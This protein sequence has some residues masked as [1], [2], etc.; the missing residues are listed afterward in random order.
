MAVTITNTTITA[1]NTIT[2][3]TSN[4]ATSSVIDATEV[5]TLTPTVPS[6]RIA[7]RI[8]VANSHG[9]VAFSV[10]ANPGYRGK[11]VTF[12]VAQNTNKYI[13]LDSSEGLSATGTVVITATPASGKRLATDHALAIEVVELP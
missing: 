10:A 6:K 8:S 13:V 9:T 7:I 3:G 12:S 4:A 1:I 2:T 11:A 5:F